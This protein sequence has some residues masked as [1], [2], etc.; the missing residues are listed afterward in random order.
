MKKQLVTLL[1][2]VATVA[3][4]EASVLFSDSFTYSDGAIVANSAGVWIYNSGTA[5]SMLNSNN[6]LVVSTSR[7]EDIAHQFSSTIA[8]NGPTAALYASMKLTFTGLP[9]QSGTYFTHF[10]GDAVTAFKARVW[11]ATT[12]IT[13]VSVAPAGSFYL[14]VGNI[15]P[16]G[17]SPLGPTNGQLTTAFTTNI[18]YT[19]VIRY[20]LATGISTIWVNTNSASMTEGGT[21]AT[22]DDAPALGNINYFGFRQATGEGTMSVDDLKVG[23]Q[24][25]DVA[26]PN[27]A[28]NISSIGN[29]AIPANG[30]TG[31]LAFVVTDAE[32][33]ATGLTVTTTSS[34]TG[35]VPN[36][37]PN[38][39]L[40]GSSTNR[41][42][43]ITPAANIQGSSTITLTVSDG[44][45]QASTVFTITV[46][47]PTIS[48]IAN[49]ITVSN[50][51]TG[52][53]S[54]TIGDAETAANSLTLN[55][56]SSNTN[57]V[58][59]AN[60]VL[61][62]SG[63]SR[64][65]TLTPAAN[66][67]GL[68]TITISVSDGTNTTQ[69]SF[70]LSVTPLLGILLA[71]DFNYTTFLLPN[72]LLQADGSPWLHGSGATSY[73]L[74]VTNGVCYLNSSLVEDL[75]APL[76]NGPFASSNAVVLYSG[77]TVKCTTLPTQSGANSY[78]A[79][80]KDSL[81]GSTFR[82]KV[83]AETNGAAAGMFRIGVANNGNASTQFPLD[84][85]VGTAYTVVTRYSSGTGEATLWVNPSTESSSSVTGTDA[86]QTTPVG[87]YAL[88]QDTGFGQIELGKLKVATSFNEVLPITAP[89]PEP[90]NIAVSGANV[91]LT[92]TNASFNLQAAP[93]VTGTY[94][95]IPG[96]ATGYSTP[97]SGEQRYFRLK[98]P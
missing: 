73:E 57:L 35:L 63:A 38:I 21:S 26:G 58:P 97:I 47:A 95:N 60:V 78:F 94:T 50:V 53:I 75:A 41:T 43:T 96:A 80:F 9:T 51:P 74:Q 93:I 15:T 36:S 87:H 52:A 29:Q 66:Q 68:T 55:A 11:A 98:Y 71:D 81:T 72:A 76:T 79:H 69:S 42:V 64:N 62:G 20:V 12:N 91:V 19:L 27:T 56:T 5:G 92:W 31:P 14:G 10:S 67:I 16:S 7:T 1:G 84:L 83:F 39:V 18:Q 45:N 49:Q 17:A 34:N 24:F 37:A 6:A 86:L 77:Y 46:G 40:S 32:T 44:V 82:A 59:T 70:K 3:S 90:L 85:A 48:A 22:A 33:V 88:R 25:A 54:F 61:G 2:L 89:T 28:P 8:S 30:N 65:V 4:V 23:T 13:S